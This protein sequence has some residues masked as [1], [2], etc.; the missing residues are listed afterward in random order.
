MNSALLPSGDIDGG[1]GPLSPVT[2]GPHVF[3]SATPPPR[4]APPRPPPPPPRPPRPPAPAAAWP[5]AGGVSTVSRVFFTGSM[6]MF[7]VPVSVVRAYQKRPSGSQVGVHAVA[8]HQ[9]VQGG[10]E[11]LDGAIVIGRRHHAFLL[12]HADG[13][14][15]QDECGNAEESG[16]VIQVLLGKTYPTSLTT[17][18]AAGVARVIGRAA[19]TTAEIAD[20]SFSGTWFPSRGTFSPKRQT[21]AGGS[22]EFGR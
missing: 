17:K 20:S 21:F 3:E 6:T 4:P 18:H 9:A 14:P 15:D 16:R 7:S 8:H 19:A 5:P 10:R 13:R 22:R 12:R 2:L 11:H 1:G